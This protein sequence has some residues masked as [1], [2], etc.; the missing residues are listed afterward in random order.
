MGRRNSIYKALEARAGLVCLKSPGYH[1]IQ[2]LL[3]GNKKDLCKCPKGRRQGLRPT[4]GS[5]HRLW[6]IHRGSTLPATRERGTE[7]STERLEFS[8]CQ[9]SMGAPPP[10]SQPLLEPQEGMMV[11]AWVLLPAPPSPHG[12]LVIM[13]LTSQAW[14]L[15]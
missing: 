14:S 6:E 12:V 10:M 8:N 9:I 11:Q 15:L 4:E 5:H 7:S 1:R 2:G 13:P 3:V